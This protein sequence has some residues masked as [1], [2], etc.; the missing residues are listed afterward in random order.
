[1][2]VTD[3]DHEGDPIDAAIGPGS[4]Q[5]GLWQGRLILFQR[6]AGAFMILKGLTYWTALL[7]TGDG[8]GSAF[9]DLPL[10]AQVVTIFFAVIDLITGVALWLGSGWGTMLW[11]IMAGI[12]MVA[13][14]LVVDLSGLTVLLTLIQL[15]F[16]GGYV[17]LRFM[18]Q[19]ERQRR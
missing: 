14:I 11:L 4:V 7:G 18:V 13:G 2:S 16:V 3:E 19:S 6:V 8:A 10:D 12:Q 1:M 9:G 17:L 15:L 5:V